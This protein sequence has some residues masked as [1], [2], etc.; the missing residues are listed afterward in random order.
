MGE[1]SVHGIT[2]PDSEEI[3]MELVQKFADR[4]AIALHRAVLR[5]DSE[6]IA[7]LLREG[8]S[9]DATLLPLSAF[10]VFF[11]HITLCPACLLAMD[12][13]SLVS[14]GS[15]EMQQSGLWPY[16]CTH[17]RHSIH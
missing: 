1:I 7:T 9:V 2:G 14:A 8:V 5:N 11:L 12:G 6:A 13:I 3:L 4:R 10:P 15:E 17:T 16:L